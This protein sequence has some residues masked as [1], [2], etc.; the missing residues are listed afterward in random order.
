MPADRVGPLKDI[1]D[2][3]D[4]DFALDLK[5]AH[6]VWRRRDGLEGADDRGGDSVI[7]VGLAVILGRLRRRLGLGVLA[8]SAAAGDAELLGDIIATV[9]EAVAAM[10]ERYETHRRAR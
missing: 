7:E 4:V 10:R 3:G 2:G 1:G 9:S 5:V 8:L 6:G